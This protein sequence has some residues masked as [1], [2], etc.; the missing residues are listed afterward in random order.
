MYDGA[1]ED[2]E[3]VSVAFS[4]PR[5]A[6]SRLLPRALSESSTVSLAPGGMEKL[7]V[8]IVAIF[9]LLPLCPLFALPAR[10]NLP[11][12][13]TLPVQAS[14]TV[15]KPCPFVAMRVARSDTVA[16]P[17]GAGPVSFGV[18]A[19]AGGHDEDAAPSGSADTE[20]ELS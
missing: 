16:A 7:T 2:F 9:D 13:V 14:L 5:C 20:T 19:G 3:I 18:G 17:G 6:L 1:G 8:P 11:L 10:I 15:A 4:G 12:Q